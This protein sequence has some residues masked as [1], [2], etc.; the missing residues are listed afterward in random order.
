[1]AAVEVHAQMAPVM[2]RSFA[3]GM[4]R[5]P[6]AVDDILGEH[7]IMA[8]RQGLTP[9]SIEILGLALCEVLHSL[10][11]M[12]EGTIPDG[13]SV[14]LWIEPTMIILS[15]SYQGPPVPNWLL[16]NWDRT[17]QP[18]FLAP[19]GDI[20]WGWLLVREAFESVSEEHSG[21]QNIIFLERRL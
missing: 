18:A 21:S 16:T 19:P 6:R 2:I 9:E 7:G 3:G 12:L 15:V 4:Q 5:I 20:G 13:A 10:H 8:V 1:M 17:Q 14:E 11:E